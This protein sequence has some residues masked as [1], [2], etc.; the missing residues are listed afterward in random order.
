ML[1]L[2]AIILD[3]PH[4]VGFQDGDEVVQVTDGLALVYEGF[5]VFV[6]LH[7]VV[8]GQVV[9]PVG[10]VLNE[11]VEIGRLLVALGEEEGEQAVLRKLP[12]GPDVGGDAFLALLGAGRR[13]LA[14]GLGGREEA[15]VGEGRGGQAHLCIDGAV[16]VG[17]ALVGFV[18][19]QHVLALDVEDDAARG[20]LVGEGHAV[21]HLLVTLFR[22]L[23]VEHGVQEE[24]GERRLG[25]HAAD[26]ADADVCALGAVEELEVDIEGLLVT[27]DADGH[28]LLHD[29]E[30]E[31]LVQVG[32][33][34]TEDIVPR[35]RGNKDL[36][37]QL[38]H[39]HRPH[40]GDAGGHDA[41]A[42]NGRVTGEGDALVVLLDVDDGAVEGNGLDT[43]IPFDRR[44]HE[45]DVIH[46]QIVV[47]VD[48]DIER[49]RRCGLGAQDESNW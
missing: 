8:G 19:E 49:Q 35:M 6:V 43:G 17:Q 5:A 30:A 27:H 2:L 38:G 7:V 28:A 13:N 48:E 9:Q 18:E 24:E 37:V 25:G 40:V 29:V 21:L 4:D 23:E 44:L 26:A 20:G 10:E 34:R 15:Q 42:H 14:V 11:A 16:V 32:A 45:D 1:A 12:H 3:R 31:R 41:L 47:L 39:L 36:G 22:A 33:R 46:L